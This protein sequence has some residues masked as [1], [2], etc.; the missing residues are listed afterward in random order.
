MLVYTAG[1][2]SSNSNNK[3]RPNQKLSTAT[4]RALPTVRKKEKDVLRIDKFFSLLPV[5]PDGRCGHVKRER[6]RR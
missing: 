5:G 1:T 4:T 3:R 2:N 6:E